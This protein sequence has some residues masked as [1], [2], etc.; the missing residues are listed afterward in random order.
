MLIVTK[1]LYLGVRLKGNI[2]HGQILEN[3][4]KILNVAVDLITLPAPDTVSVWV[5]IQDNHTLLATL[6]HETPQ[7]QICIEFNG[8]HPQFYLHSQSED[9][10]RDIEVYLSGYTN[11]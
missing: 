8:E 2:R 10:L 7:A 3:H 11:E 9:V 5:Y 6:S 4:T 1:L